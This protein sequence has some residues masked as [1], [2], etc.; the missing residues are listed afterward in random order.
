MIHVNELVQKYKTAVHIPTT[1]IGLSKRKIKKNKK[2]KCE[3][4]TL[5]FFFCFFV[6]CDMTCIICHMLLSVGPFKGLVSF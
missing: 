3:V 6:F 2:N 1:Q 4:H 5:T